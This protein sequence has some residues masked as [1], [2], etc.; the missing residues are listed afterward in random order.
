MPSSRPLLLSLSQHSEALIAREPF[1]FLYLVLRPPPCFSLESSIHSAHCSEMAGRGRSC[2]WVL[3]VWLTAAVD[4]AVGAHHQAAAPAPA[5]DCSSALLG[6]SDCL[7]FVEEGSTEVK[8]QKGCCAG[9]KKVVKG[10]Q[11]SC[12]C[13]AFKQGASFGVKLNMTKALA[14]PS[15]C[16][17]ST[18]HLSNC[19]SGFFF[20]SFFFIMFFFLLRSLKQWKLILIFLVLQLF[21]RG[22][23]VH[24]LLHL[25]IPVQLPG[26]ALLHL[27]LQGTQVQLLPCIL[28]QLED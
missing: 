4:V 22:V 18:P 6:L 19:N 16:G 17:I 7:T 3:L 13:D 8:P 27:H 24:L 25:Q 11:V 21:F 10:G 2:A 26:L 20:F 5:V 14:L 1:L 15:A 9:L 12:L 28:S 23:L